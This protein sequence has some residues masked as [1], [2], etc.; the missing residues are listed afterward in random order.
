MTGPSQ[1]TPRVILSEAESLG[2]SCH[3][4]LYQAVAGGDFGNLGRDWGGDLHIAY[5]GFSSLRQRWEANGVDRTG[6]Y[7]GALIVT[8]IGD[9]ASGL[10]DPASAQGIETLQHLYWFALTAQAKGCKVFAIYPPHSPEGLD[11]DADAMAKAQY[12]AEWLRARSEVTIPVYIIP[13]PVMVRAMIQR[14]APTSVYADGLH[15]KTLAYAPPNHMNAALAQMI[16]M[17]LTGER[18]QNAHWSAE[19]SELVDIAWSI[20]RDHACTG[21]GGPII[22]AAYPVSGDPLP[23]P[24]P[25]PA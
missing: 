13:V 20:L 10:A 23:D 16:R 17:F 8:E 7:A 14:F 5:A 2:F 9:L 11:M 19:L 6:A 21:F 4:F 24:A 18:A 3:S 25:L 15:L 22:T 12:W 1:P